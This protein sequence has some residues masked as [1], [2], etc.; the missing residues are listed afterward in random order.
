M[1]V[2]CI[3]QVS[4]TVCGRWSKYAYRSPSGSLDRVTD[5]SSRL[6]IRICHH[7]FVH[8]ASHAFLSL[9]QAPEQWTCPGWS[10]YGPVQGP[11]AGRSTAGD[12][13]GMRAQTQNQ[14]FSKNLANA[15]FKLPD[16]LFSCVSIY[17]CAFARCFIQSTFWPCNYV[18][19]TV[20]INFRGSRLEFVF[21]NIVHWCWDLVFQKCFTYKPHSHPAGM[22][23]CP[24]HVT[25]VDR[26]HWSL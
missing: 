25:W 23:F 2:H 12:T 1:C 8:N 22:I 19:G 20:T 13:G 18:A 26:D 14:H 15:I 5:W 4:D 9:S 17:I 16:Y 11:D 10:Q 7:M 6:C 3:R 24:L 21:T